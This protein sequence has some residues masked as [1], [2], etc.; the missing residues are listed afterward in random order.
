MLIRWL[1]NP[2][3]I[4]V[5]ILAIACAGLAYLPTGFEGAQPQN[6]LRAKARVISID[7]TGIHDVRIIKTGTQAIRAE[8]ISG[9]HKGR[10]IQVENVLK[11]SLEVDELYQPGDVLLAE[12]ATAGDGSITVA[13]ARGKYRTDLSLLL[14]GLFG[15]LLVAVAGFTGAKAMLS[16]VFAVLMLWKVL[17]PAILRGHDPILV[18]L[19]VATLLIGAICFLVG[20]MGRK[21]LV[22][23]L[24]SFLGMLLTCGL[25]LLFTRKFGIN[26]AVQPY[27]TSLMYAGYLD[28]NLTRLFIASIFL[29]SSGALMDVAMD[30]AAAMHEIREQQPDIGLREHIASGLSVGRAVIGTMTT[31]LLLA[32][33]GGYSA[34]LMLFM[35]Q[36]VPLE[37]VFNLSHVSAEVLHTLVGSFGLIAVAPFTAVAGGFIYRGRP[38]ARAVPA[39]AS[40]I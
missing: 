14:L 17:Y 9:P 35:G 25:A 7:N 12:Y 2:D 6:S 1:R 31:T 38:A 26:G 40:D 3:L 22:T 27:A 29:A 39:S 19:G 28:I 10:P 23:F 4:F 30:I 13:Y 37:N 20:G 33:S 15:V 18:S 34:M 24:G 16:F 11:G 5:L 8:L 36:G 21:G 32:Y